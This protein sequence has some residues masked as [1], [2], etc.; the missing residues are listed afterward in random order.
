MYVPGIG[1]AAG[2]D[3]RVP[4]D[5]PPMMQEHMLGNMRDH[6]VALAEIQGALAEGAFDRAAE[7]AERRLGMSSL[8][9]HGATHMAGF[10]PIEMQRIG[11]AMHRA[12]SDFAVL[13]EQAGV[14][15]DLTTPMGA[16]ARITE[17][18]VACHAA[19]RIR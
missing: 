4:V 16:L 7:V 1:W 12:A 15:G 2:D 18:C 9:S 10:M 13:A 17:Q 6:L 5:F 3:Q 11:T 8:Q 14:D 19:F